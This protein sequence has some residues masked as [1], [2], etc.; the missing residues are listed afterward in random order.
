MTQIGREKGSERKNKY[1]E[2]RCR[3]DVK[4]RA[5]DGKGKERKKGRKRNGKRKEM[6]VN[7]REGKK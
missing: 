5:S 6:K 2:R 1:A 4:E 3:N 7:E